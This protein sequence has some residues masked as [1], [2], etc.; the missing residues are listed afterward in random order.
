MLADPT[1]EEHEHLRD[2]VGNRLAACDQ[3]EADRQVRRMVGEVPASVRLVLDLA[4]DGVKL[5]PGGR[6]PRSFVRAVQEQ[7]PGWA[8]S[9]RLASIEDDLPP[10]S[11]LHDRLRAV[12]LLRLYRGVLTPTKAST[13][14]LDLVRRLRSWFPAGKFTTIVSEWTVSTLA[15]AGPQ[16]PHALA[17][18][19][20]PKLG[21][22]WVSDG[23]P[24]TEADVRQ[25]IYSLSPMLRGLDLVETD[26]QDWRAGPSARSLLPGTTIITA[27]WP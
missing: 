16:S 13:A 19:V 14:D 11:V 27:C 7:L 21:R 3:A 15:A 23:Q 18:A 8:W 17:L 9:E 6:L 20:F 10:L 24:L 2:W 5:T 26:L 25:T 22:G 12:G 4:K 1:H